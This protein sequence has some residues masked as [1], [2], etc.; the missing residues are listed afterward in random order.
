VDADPGRVQH[1][2]GFADPD[3]YRIAEDATD[4][5]RDLNEYEA[6]T[7]G[8]YQAL[9]EWDYVSAWGTPVLTPLMTDVDGQT[10]PVQ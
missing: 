3:I 9:P 6:G 1:R 10:A 8:F 7:N 2:T 4:Y 5:A